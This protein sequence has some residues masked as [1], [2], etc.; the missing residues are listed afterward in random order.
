MTSSGVKTAGS[1]RGCAIT[2]P[3]DG[4]PSGK[5]KSVD[6]ILNTLSISVSVF[7]RLFFTEMFMLT[8][9]RLSDSIQ[10]WS[11]LFERVPVNVVQEC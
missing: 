1:K 8:V 9:W 4:I 6:Q 2:G 11:E 3:W 7:E 5:R 10:E